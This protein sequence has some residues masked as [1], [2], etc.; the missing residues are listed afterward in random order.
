M[1]EKT[2]VYF[3]FGA[4]SCWVVLPSLRA[5]VVYDQPGHYRFFY[6]DDTLQDT[7]TGIELPISAIFA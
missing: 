5:V 4:K 3:Q 1:V 7:V 2:D 6:E